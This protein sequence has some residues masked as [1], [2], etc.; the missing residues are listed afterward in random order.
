MGKAKILI[1]EL[2]E[3][4]AKGNAF[5]IYNVR[6]KLMLKGIMVDKITESSNEPF[7][8]VVKIYEVAKDFNIELRKLN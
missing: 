8:V 3:K 7:D 5:Q 6:M 2:I 1:D 4:K